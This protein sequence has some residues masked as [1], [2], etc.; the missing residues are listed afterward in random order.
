[1]PRMPN[2]F[3]PAQFSIRLW[4]LDLW[5]ACLSIFESNRNALSAIYFLLPRIRDYS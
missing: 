4:Q 5:F 3:N 1:M 2:F